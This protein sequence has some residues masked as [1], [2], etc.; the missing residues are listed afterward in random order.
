MSSIRWAQVA[1]WAMDCSV[2]RRALHGMPRPLE[3]AQHSSPCTR[4]GVPMVA[5]REVKEVDGHH[6]NT[7]PKYSITT[8]PLP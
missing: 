6:D 5:L 8:P 7:P 2:G 4:A 3:A 1:P